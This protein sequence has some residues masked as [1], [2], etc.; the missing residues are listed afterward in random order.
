MEFKYIWVEGKDYTADNM[1]ENKY[2]LLKDA[3]FLRFW[4]AVVLCHDVVV[5][6]RS[7]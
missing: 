2:Q 6:V 3:D 7:N 1:I 5:D 4:T